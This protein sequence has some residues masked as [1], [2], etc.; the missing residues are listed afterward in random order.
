MLCVMGYLYSA[1]H[2]FTLSLFSFYLLITRR[3]S[4]RDQ[5]HVF[6]GINYAEL[7]VYRGCTVCWSLLYG[8]VR[9]MRIRIAYGIR[10]P[11]HGVMSNLKS[12]I[13]WHMPSLLHQTPLDTP[14]TGHSSVVS[15]SVYTVY[16]H[17]QTAR[18]R[19]N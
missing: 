15:A 13:S 4:C 17:I 2:R 19:R 1:M 14:R 16:G 8:T 5:A 11:Y 9:Y 7:K 12:S 6:R 18:G 3:V 10:I